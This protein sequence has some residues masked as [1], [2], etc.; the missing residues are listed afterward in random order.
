L[1]PRSGAIAELEDMIELS[2]VTAEVL[3][4]TSVDEASELSELPIP[5][6]VLAVIENLL[7]SIIDVALEVLKW[8]ISA[9]DE[10]ADA[11]EETL[12]A[13]VER[14]E[15]SSEVVVTLSLLVG[16]TEDA[17]VPLADAET[18]LSVMVLD[19]RLMS[20]LIVTLSSER[21]GVISVEVK[22]SL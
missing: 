14:D 17:I 4:I 12:E 2:E 20:E 21:V 3:V 7:S 1:H 8:E 22:D 5:K 9:E 16:S 11:S 19:D 15:L 13:V 18:G 6:I 10:V